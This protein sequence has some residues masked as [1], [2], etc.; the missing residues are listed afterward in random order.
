MQV[1]RQPQNP[2]SDRRF[3]FIGFMLIRARRLAMIRPGNGAGP[4]E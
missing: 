1:G 4:R 2:S 3:S